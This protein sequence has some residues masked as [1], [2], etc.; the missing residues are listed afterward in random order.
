MNGAVRMVDAYWDRFLAV[1]PLFATAV[2]D[3]RF[4]D[5]LPDPS[6]EGRAERQRVHAGL[7]EAA[8]RVD[9]R[10][11]ITSSGGRCCWRWRWPAVSWAA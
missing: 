4:D 10:V 11:W 9:P 2:G 8:A 7:L 5:L 1:E 3:A 6:E